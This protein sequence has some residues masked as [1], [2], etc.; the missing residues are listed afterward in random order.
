MKRVIYG[1]GIALLVILGLLNR[2]LLQA[3]DGPLTNAANLGVRTDENGYLLASSGT[4]GA[5]DGPLT[6]FGNIK[7][8]TDENGYLRVACLDCGTGG[9]PSNATYITQTADAVLTNEQAIGFLSS[10]IMRVSTTDG[11]I[12]SLT[13]S[14]GLAANLSD[15]TGSGG[16]FVRATSP[17]IATV[18]TSGS[19]PAVADVGAASCGATAATIVGNDNQFRI[20]VGAGAG[21][22]CRVTFTTTA[23]NAWD[24]TVTDSTTTI[25]TRATAVDTTH[26][27][28]L[29]AFGG[30]DVVTGLCSRR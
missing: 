19:T 24:C 23:P 13:N 21:T 11:V 17:T 4:P 16:G 18:I 25:A 5:I 12:T 14:A 20:T 2:V 3:T 9:A 26:T 6:A 29:G 1:I 28:F 30:G 22:Q 27:D 10:G 7:V 8:R 15:E